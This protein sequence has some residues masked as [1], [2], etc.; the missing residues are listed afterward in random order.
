VTPVTEAEVRALIDE[1]PDPCSLAAGVPAG[2]AEMGL[3][4]ALAVEHRPDGTRV[5]ATLAV[6]EPG[7]FLGASFARSA[8]ERLLAHPGIVAADVD[9]DHTHGWTPD[10][11]APAY[12]ARLAA[13]RTAR[14]ATLPLA[15][16]R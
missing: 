9:L 10:D 7:C 4:R 1:V 8:T 11:M 14:R 2:L 15:A 5:R 6:T 3:L 13:A 12:Q 16:P